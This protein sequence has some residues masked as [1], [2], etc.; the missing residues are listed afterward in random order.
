MSDA[1]F[2]PGYL[3][4]GRDDWKTMDRLKLFDRAP[5]LKPTS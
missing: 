4:P 1:G 2:P 3:Y 5:I